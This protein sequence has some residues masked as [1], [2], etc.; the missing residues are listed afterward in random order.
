[1]NDIFPESLISKDTP[2]RLHATCHTMA[3]P[4]IEWD[5]I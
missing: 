2:G 3:P 1:M 4:R 5:D